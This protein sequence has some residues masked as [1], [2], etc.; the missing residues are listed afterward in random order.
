MGYQVGVTPLQMVAAVSSVANGGELVEP[1]VVRAMYRDGRRYAV[2]PKV[3]RRTISAGHRRHADRR[4]W[5][6]SSKRGTAQARPD[7]R[8]HDRRQDRHRLASSS[9]AATRLR[10]QRVVRRLSAVAQPR[11]HDHRRHRR[12]ARRRSTAAAS[13][14]APIFKRIAEADAA[15]SR[16]CRRRS[17]RRR[18]CWSRAATM[19]AGNR[20][21]R[22]CEPPIVNWSRTVG[23]HGARSARHERARGDA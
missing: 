10:E 19:P 23:R 20:P 16:H 2:E 13:S 12:A 8:L 9:T 21:P 18:R 1:R 5:K 6:R 22:P 3:V 17:I 11:G 4:S 7:P 15:L 14:S